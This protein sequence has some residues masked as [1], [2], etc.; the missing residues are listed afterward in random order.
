[1]DCLLL[2]KS[3][4]ENAAPILP[5]IPLVA[6]QR[7]DAGPFLEYPLRRG[8]KSMYDG[9]G[10]TTEHPWEI[11]PAAAQLSTKAWEAF[12][13]EWLFFGLIIESLGGNSDPLSSSPSPRAPEHNDESAEENSALRDRQAIVDR[14]YR[15][16]V[17]Q[18]DAL[19]YIT[20]RTFLLDLQNSWSISLLSFHPTRNRLAVRCKRMRLCLRQANYFYTHLPADFRSDI[21][22]SIGA[23]AE[24]IAHA[25]QPVC[26]WLK[27]D[28]I[29]PNEWGAGYYAD[30]DVLSRMVDNGWCKSHMDRTTHSFKY[31]QTLHYMSYLDKR[32]SAKSHTECDQAECVTDKIAATSGIQ[33]HWTDGCSWET[34]AV[35]HEDLVSALR[36][37]DTVPLLRIRRGGRAVE[38]TEGATDASLEEKELTI[39]VVRSTTSTPYIAISHIWADGLANKEANSLNACKLRELHDVVQAL[40]MSATTPDSANRDSSPVER[41]DQ[42]PLIWLDTLCCP[43]AP[44][45]DKKLALTK[46][47]QVYKQASS[48]LVLESSL[49]SY[50]TASMDTLE[51][52]A[53]IF[54]SRWLRRLWT[55]E[56]GALAKRLWFQFADRAVSLTELKAKMETI[57][58]NDLQQKIIFFDTRHEIDRVEQFFQT[59]G[60]DGSGPN[61][62][63]LD[64]ALLHRGVSNA[65]DEPI[66]IGTLLNLPAKAIL[67]PGDDILEALRKNNHG[68]EEDRLQLKLRDVRM[69]VVWKLLAEKFKSLPAQIIFFEEP[70]IDAPGFRWA[71]RS[72]LQAENVYL[73]PASRKLRWDDKKPGILT[74]TGLQVSYPGFRLDLAQYNDGK[75]RHPWKGCRRIPENGI[76]FR[77]S[78]SGE[79]Y[80]VSTKARA[81]EL[82]HGSAMQNRSEFPLHDFLHHNSKPQGRPIE[83]F[84]LVPEIDQG[85]TPHAQKNAVDGIL[86]TGTF[87][88][89]STLTWLLSLLPFGA[90]NSRRRTILAKSQYQ[91]VVGALPTALSTLYNT[92]EQLALRLRG[93]EVTDRLLALSHLGV[94]ND[95]YR[96][97]LRELEQRMK[98]MMR[99]VLNGDEPLRIGMRNTWGDD[100]DEYLWVSIADWFNHAFLGTRLGD[101]QMWIVD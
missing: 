79:W 89:P 4:T 7:W 13:Q 58:P 68:G 70:R 87:Q 46:I 9:A 93:E 26:Y 19:S 17:Y 45:E 75:P 6:E 74:D 101:D 16:F 86:M 31:L 15:D 62:R 66:C 82:R 65:S 100:I 53:R 30:K 94:E 41:G 90:A 28:E 40:P 24:T 35:N 76:L 10:G 81:M 3:T 25:M 77:D 32:M 49:R 59:K 52:L 57:W 60:Y 56:E 72:F 39:Q 99:E 18:A 47:H 98:D 38:S 23:V 20:T 51:V 34:V 5:R 43:V 67:A 73:G 92:T 42:C 37:K 22:F 55:L 54:T 1:M 80:S 48:V 78:S 11:S 44:K 29:C 96:V 91:V 85:E 27:L 14:V 64:E 69:K 2:P 83:V 84:L 12:F 97:V 63:I 33:G 50:S 71:P 21:K 95:E 8:F 61:L 88:E 36:T